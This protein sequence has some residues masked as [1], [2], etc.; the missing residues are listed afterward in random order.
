MRL[1]PCCWEPAIAAAGPITPKP[2]NANHYFGEFIQDDI[3]WSRKLTM[4]VGFRLE[5]ETGTTERYNRMAAIDPYVLSPLSKDVTQPLHRTNA[6]EFVWRIRFCR[7]RRRQSRPQCHPT[8]RV[9]AEPEAWNRL[10]AG[11]Q[12]GHPDR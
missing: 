6:L 11:R 10:C 9:E 2:A 3:K 12:D 1:L 5:Q 7:E 8:H 4:N